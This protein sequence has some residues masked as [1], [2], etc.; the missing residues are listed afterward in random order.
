MPTTNRRGPQGGS[1]PPKTYDVNIGV[2]I[3]VGFV[4][5][6]VFTAFVVRTAHCIFY[7]QRQRAEAKLDDRKTTITD[8]SIKGKVRPIYVLQITS[9]F[10]MLCHVLVIFFQAGYTYNGADPAYQNEVPKSFDIAFVFAN[11]LVSVREGS[12]ACKIFA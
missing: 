7:F 8:L 12:E 9:V 3:F 1:A 10:T 4:A 11:V 5:L 2:S 6:I